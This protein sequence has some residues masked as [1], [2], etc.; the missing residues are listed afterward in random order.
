M[1]SED[2][3]LVRSIYDRWER[4]DFHDVSWADPEIAFA[5]RDGPTQVSC[6][7]IEPMSKEWG[8]FLSNWDGLRAKAEEYRDLGDGRV[9]TLVRNTGTGKASGV[10]LSE[11]QSRGANLFSVRDGKVTRLDVYWDRDRAFA[12][13]G[14]DPSAG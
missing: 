2:V 14:I 12:D 3:D 4:G 9:L 11:M 6:T 7:G 5:L 8:E 10:E 13:L 1:A